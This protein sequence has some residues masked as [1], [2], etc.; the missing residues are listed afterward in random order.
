MPQSATI[1]PHRRQRFILPLF[2]LT[3]AVGTTGARSAAASSHQE[4]RVATD[5]ADVVAVVQRFHSALSSGDSTGALALLTPDVRILEGGNVETFAQYRSGHL[6][7]DIRASA[8][9]QSTQT[10]SQVAVL[11]DAAWVVSTS[12]TQRTSAAGATT[13]SAGAESMMLKRTSAGWK[14]AVIHWSSGRAR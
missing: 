8:G 13:T 3:L 9:A 5:S 2:A 1:P 14:I 12:R 11:G 7:A 10:L 6:A 4:H